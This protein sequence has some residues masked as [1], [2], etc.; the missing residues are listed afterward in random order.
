MPRVWPSIKQLFLDD[1]FNES[2]NLLLVGF[3]FSFADDLLQVLHLLG[4]IVEDKL[5]LV[6][7]LDDFFLNFLSLQQLGLDLLGMR[8]NRSFKIL[9]IIDPLNS[10]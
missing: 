4:E 8:L 6:L 3:V 5:I 10:F 7:D 9:N 2:F 1:L